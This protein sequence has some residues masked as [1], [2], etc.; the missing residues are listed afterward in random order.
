MTTTWTWRLL[1]AGSFRLDGGGM[2]GVVPKTMWTRLTEPDEQDRIPLQTNCLL[3]ERDGERVLVET[4]YGGKW[5]EK[6][7]GFFDLERRTVL[8]ALRE[9]GV[10]PE[11]IGTVI[12]SHLH[13]DHAGGLT[14]LDGAGE[15]VGSFP[16]A[17]IVVQRREW[18]DARANKSTM[19][20]TYL[21]GHLDP[22]ADRVDLVDGAAEVRPGIHVWPVPGHTWGQHAIRFDDGSSTVAFVGDVMPTASHAGLAFNM[23]YDME[24]YRN[25]QTKKALLERAAAEGWRLALDHEPGAPIVR[26]EPDGDRAGRYVL[27]ADS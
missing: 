2:F 9:V 22:V 16:R 25:T 7:R 20:R 3:L 5:S 17:R 24:P 4:G 27:T 6:E 26:V 18:E 8:D 19:T 1:R 15:P 21:P 11:S 13:F 12:V 14:Q 23:G 10:E